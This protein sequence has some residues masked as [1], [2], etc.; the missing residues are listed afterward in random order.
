M[1]RQCIFCE[2]KADSL[3]HLWPQWI[4]RLVPKPEAIRI[5]IGNLPSKIIKK[6]DPE[7]K[8]VCF[9]CNEGWMHDLEN[10]VIPTLGKMVRDLPLTLNPEEQASIAAW[11]VKVAMISDST[12]AS[13]RGLFYSEQERERLRVALEI[14]ARTTVL[15][16]RFE[17]S[18]LL[19]DGSTLRGD[20][21]AVRGVAHNC[22][23]TIVV[24]HVALQV[25]TIHPIPE[26]A[27]RPMRFTPRQ[28]P[29]NRLV[30]Q[31]WPS[32]APA[33]WPPTFSFTNDRGML[34]IGWLQSRWRMGEKVPVYRLE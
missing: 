13:L 1:A 32:V 21:D 27:D 29:W 17:L 18:S 15:F 28:G 12:V 22:V 30:S 16:G 3:E 10:E 7:V 5:Q 26:F 2:Q 34:S 8:T 31:L 33:K 19:L 11:A 20:Q 24:G 25:F 9:K 6:T 4:L 14:P 23:T